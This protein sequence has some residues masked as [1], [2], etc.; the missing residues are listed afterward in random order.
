[1]SG[2]I[3]WHLGDTFGVQVWLDPDR[4]GHSSLVL[5]E[6]DLDAVAERLAAAGIPHNGPQRADPPARRPR[7]QQRSSH[8]NLNTERRPNR[9]YD[10]GWA[11]PAVEPLTN[12]L[13]L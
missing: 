3:E 8:R 4:A 12:L 11:E 2:Q 6:T 1:M 5:E 7:R 10:F 9:L 13:M